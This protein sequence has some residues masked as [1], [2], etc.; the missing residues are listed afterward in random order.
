MPRCPSCQA[1]LAPKTSVC[2]HDGTPIPEGLEGKILGE[3]YRI[4][5]ELGEGGMGRVY[6]AEHVILGKQLA[7]K[8][9]REEYS[10]LPDL[11]KR[12]QLEAVAAS[13]IGQENIVDVKDFGQ[14]PEGLFYFVMEFVPGRSLAQL[15][16]KSGAMPAPRAMGVL[17]QIT[18]ALGA[19]HSRGIIHRDLKPDNV[20]ITRK[21]DGTEHAKVLDFGISKVGEG[22]QTARITQVGMVVGT[23]HYMAPEQ[24]TGGAVDLR[25]DIYALGVLAY[26]MLTG[27]VP[28]DG[29]SSLAILLKHQRDL[30]VPPRESRP[31]LDISP[32]LEKLVLKCL[33]KDRGDRPQSMGEV[34]RELAACMVESGV[35]SGPTPLV[36]AAIP[37]Q[38]R[39]TDAR[40]AAADPDTTPVPV[41]EP[42]SSRPKPI[43]APVPVAVEP[44][45]TKPERKP[46]IRI[47]DSNPASGPTLSTDPVQAQLVA[48]QKSKRGLLIGLIAFILLGVVAGVGALAFH[49]GKPEVEKVAIAPTAPAPP[50][51]AAPPTAPAPMPAPAPVAVAAVAPTPEP[52]PAPATPKDHAKSAK[53]TVLL[54]STPSGA[55][56]LGDQ[57]APLGHTPMRI[58]LAA[59]ESKI[60]KLQAAGY[61]EREAMVHAGDEKLA[62]QLEKLTA[63]AAPPQAAKPAPSSSPEADPYGKVDD[64]KKNPYGP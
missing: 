42:V 58:E 16:D 17:L 45:A 41:T 35:T 48:E 31:D 10:R 61:R 21:P 50:P 3:R 34:G 62:L 1:E 2:P 12:F 51:P 14:T 22:P 11:V 30:P 24:A 26:E 15:I 39:A 52:A 13:Q 40:G 43:A 63:Q 7:V 25:V 44:P 32:K 5:R 46:Q 4:T 64:L 28:F 37:P 55:Q 60:V 18:K 6:L 54:I 29:E 49:T 57:G 59:G 47:G 36:L 53:Q 27:K 19:A 8:V 56:V 23:P 9:L 38:A 33:E 20:L